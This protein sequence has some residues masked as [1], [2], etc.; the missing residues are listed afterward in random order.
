MDLVIPVIAMPDIAQM[1]ARTPV[2]YTKWEE[3]N[4]QI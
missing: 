1:G 4:E 2:Q 3:K